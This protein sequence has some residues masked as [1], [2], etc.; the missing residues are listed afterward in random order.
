MIFQTTVVMSHLVHQETMEKYSPQRHKEH[1]G[2]CSISE[3]RAVVV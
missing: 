1:D 2:F 3:S